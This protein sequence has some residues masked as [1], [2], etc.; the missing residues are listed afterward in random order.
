MGK[1]GIVQ[2]AIKQIYL[3]TV[4]FLLYVDDFLK[5]KIAYNTLSYFN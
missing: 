2:G 1:K 3:V 5:S 4:L